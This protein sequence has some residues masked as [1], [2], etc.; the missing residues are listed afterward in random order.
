MDLMQQYRLEMGTKFK[1]GSTFKSL[2]EFWDNDITKQINKDL[3][4]ANTSTILNLASNEYF[5][6]VKKDKLKGDIIDIHFREYKGSE[7]K[8]VSFTA[9][10]ARGMMAHF[11]VKNKIK[12]IEALKDFDYENYKFETDLSSENELY[13]VR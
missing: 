3:K 5:K 13:F 12:E 6:S 9:K 4:A 1:N 8:F 11:V 2:Y 7:L 10:V